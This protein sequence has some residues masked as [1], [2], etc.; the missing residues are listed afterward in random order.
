MDRPRNP[1]PTVDV[2]VET[3]K[4]IVLVERAKEPRGWALPGGFIDY[5]EPAEDAARREVREETGLQVELTDLLGVYSDPERDP[6]QHNLSVVYVGRAQGTPVGAD[7]AAH[8]ALFDPERLPELLCFDHGRILDDYRR[9]RRSGQRPAPRPPRGPGLAESDRDALL[10][11]ARDALEAAVTGRAPQPVNGEET[12]ALLRPAACFVTLHMR[13]GSLR[14]CIGTL[15]G[16]QALSKE[17]R[18]MTAAAALRDPRFPPVGSAELPHLRIGLSVLSPAHP[19][20][21]PREV[22]VGR[23]GL[24]IERGP[25]RGVLL[26]QVPVEQGWDRETF[27]AHTCRKAGLP[28]DAWEDPDTTISVFSADVFEEP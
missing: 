24:V 21:D 4:G 10:R 17:V 1:F 13:D 19:I 16:H 3:P 2:V 6:R 9:L 7:D 23:H 20:R 11:I 18:E 12:P 15:E 26:P 27:L 14:G 25:A 28:V 8:A 22:E 5:G